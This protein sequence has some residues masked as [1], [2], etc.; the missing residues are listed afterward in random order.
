[1]FHK[2]CL[3]QWLMAKRADCCPICRSSILTED[4][5]RD[6]HSQIA[7]GRESDAP[8]GEEGNDGEE[9]AAAAAAVAE[10]D[11]DDEDEEQMHEAAA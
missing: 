8:E 4:E 3:E 6:I 9:M 10:E 1:M 11:G 2:D 7:T 5:W